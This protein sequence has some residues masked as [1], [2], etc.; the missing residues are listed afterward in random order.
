MQRPEESE[1]VWLI[2]GTL[3]RW[4]GLKYHYVTVC[5]RK[6]LA[7]KTPRHSQKAQ[8]QARPESEQ[9]VGARW[10]FHGALA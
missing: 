1:N 2:G 10:W 3:R 4:R 5:L 6:G 9:S 8:G 7:V